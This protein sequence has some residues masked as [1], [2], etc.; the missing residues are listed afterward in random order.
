MKVD[1]QLKRIAYFDGVHYYR[2]LNVV[3]I[4]MNFLYLYEMVY[5]YK[6]EQGQQNIENKSN[7]L[8]IVVHVL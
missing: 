8:E 5:F 4:T 2:R 7:Q 3:Y 6:L 1:T